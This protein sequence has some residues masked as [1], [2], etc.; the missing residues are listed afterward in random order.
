VTE[1]GL[2]WQPLYVPTAV[3]DT[4]LVNMHK[5]MPFGHS[6]GDGKFEVRAELAACVIVRERERLLQVYSKQL[7]I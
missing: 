7:K 5:N 2:Y 1:L 3:L 4:I 6:C